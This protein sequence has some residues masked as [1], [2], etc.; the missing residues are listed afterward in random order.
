MNV[1]DQELAEVSLELR[2]TFAATAA[3][4]DRE[5][6]YPEENMRLIEASPL[7][8]LSVPRSRGGR[9]ADGI[10]DDLGT[11]V[12]VISNLAAGESSTA[13]IWMFS[14]RPSCWF[15]GEHSPL[16]VEGREAIWER[17][18]TEGRIMRFCTTGTERAQGGKIAKIGAFEMPAKRVEGGVVINGT[19][20]FGTGVDG[21]DYANVHVVEEGF[22]NY[23]V[24]PYEV[25]VDLRSEGITVKGDW[26]NMGQRATGSHTVV[27]DNVF[28]P[29][30]FHWRPAETVV[31]P[32]GPRTQLMMAAIALGIGL[33]ALDDL[34]RF[35]RNRAS[36][37][38]AKDD[39]VIQWQIGRYTYRLQ[40]AQA[41]VMAGVP[42]VQALEAGE[43]DD[44]ENVAA[45]VA[46]SKL[47]ALDAGGEIAGEMQRM[48]GGSSSSNAF[49]MDRHWRNLRT[50]SVQD[51]AD[52]R[53]RQ[54]GRNRLYEGAAGQP[55]SENAPY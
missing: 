7:G 36:F 11:Y 48:C 22:E 46:A 16:P 29:D 6:K 27:Y 37:P 35:Q 40:A 9:G 44:V 53:Q 30:G 34:V 45:Y 33:G 26:D 55:R 47:A 42:M 12:E 43:R 52:L 32:L 31:A 20:A 4:V 14:T 8:R 25:L 1:V 51:P 13:Q 15:L 19:K 10:I 28:V 54:V 38:G 39:A 49:G 2:R 24:R 41:M 18:R 50:F 5:G 3:K 21:A 17:V 23:E